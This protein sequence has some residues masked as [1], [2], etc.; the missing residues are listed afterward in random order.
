[1]EN[2]RV[3]WLI[4]FV[5][6]LVVGALLGIA[7]KAQFRLHTAELPSTRLPELA[8]AYV[9]EKRTVQ[10]ME[11]EIRQLRQ[12]MTELENALA[13]GTKQTKVLNDSLQ[14]AKMLAGLV[15]VEGPGIELILRDSERRPAP[16]STESLLIDLYIIHDY[17]LLRVVNELRQAGAEAIAIN[18]QRLVATSAIRCV[19]PV[20]YINDIKMASPFVIHAIGDPNTLLGALKTPGGVLSDIIDADPKMV[21]MHARDRVRIPAYTGSTQFRFAKPVPSEEVTK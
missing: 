7:L 21:E 9:Q 4:F 2:K 3:Q 20:I 13:T 5:I 15:E 11:N 14:A 18:G 1:M 16:G 19:G 8:R 6:W 10:A 17:D 12:K